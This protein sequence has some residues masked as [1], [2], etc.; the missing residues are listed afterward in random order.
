[1]IEGCEKQDSPVEAV[2][3]RL[4]H[5]LDESMAAVHDLTKRLAPILRAPCPTPNVDLPPGV[6]SGGPASS[7]L[8]TRL[9]D[10]TETACRIGEAIGDILDRLE[11]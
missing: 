2:V 5:K 10:R 4:G 6:V 11:V 8:T 9:R 1:M 7:P 3:C